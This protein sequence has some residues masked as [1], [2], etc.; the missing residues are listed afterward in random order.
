MS[1]RENFLRAVEMRSPEW[2]PCRVSFL[3]QVWRKYR[4]DLEAL[5]LRH[6][7]I[8]GNYVPDS[9]DYDYLGVQYRGNRVIDEWKCVWLYAKDGMT[10]QVVE[11]P[12]D[13][14]GKLSS[15]RPPEYPLWGP[16]D[17]GG[18]PIK[19]S[20]YWVDRSLRKAREEGRLT[21]GSVPHG[22]MFMRLQFLRGFKNLMMDFVREDPRLDDLI[23][24]VLDRNLSLIDRW[25][26][27]GPLDML[28]FGDDLG[29]QDRMPVRPEVFRRY[30]IPAYEEMFGRIRDAGSHVY[31]HSDGYF[32]DVMDDLIRSGVTVLNP[33]DALHGFASLKRTLKGKVCIDLDIDRQ[34]LLPRGSRKEILDHIGAAVRHL[35]SR[36]GGLMLFAGVAEDV[37]LSNI[38]SV[39]Q[40][41]ERFQRRNA[42]E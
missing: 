26:E 9:T 29:M 25:L 11:H 4:E 12:L 16:P 23:A 36:R 21:V 7:A 31:L 28:R 33:Q 1:V 30:I 15:Y 8:F 27:L 19:A 38:E 10:G 34:H 14:W 40:A 18:R 3:H 41:M 5:V 39:C 24:M 17:G 32:L 22:F 42:P 35:G 13:D 20:W 2:I 37:P 6:P